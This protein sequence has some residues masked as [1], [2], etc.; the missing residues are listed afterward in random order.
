MENN[1]NVNRKHK[2][3]LFRM[4]FNDREALLSLYNAVNDSNYMDSEAI[5]IN[6]IEDVVYMGMKNDNS[7]LIANYLNL[8]EAQSTW[9]PNMPLR[10][11]FYF[12]SLFRGYIAQNKLDIYSE[13]LI[14]LPIPQYI[15]FYNGTRNIGERMELRLSDSFFY[16]EGEPADCKVDTGGTDI[17]DHDGESHIYHELN[18]HSAQPALECVVTY[19]N[20]NYGHNQEIVSKCR[21]LYEYSYLVEQ[22]RIEVRS[23]KPIEEAVD[24]AVR[25]CIDEGILADFLRRHRAEVMDMILTEYDEDLHIRSEKQISRKEGWED[26]RKK[27]WEDGRKKGWEDGQKKGHADGQKEEKERFVRT[28]LQ[29]GS[30]SDI[31][32]ADFAELPLERILEIKKDC[33]L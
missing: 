25:Q 9:N 8:Y 33:N 16:E 2:D 23:G 3:S 4:I 17:C 18:G 5:M 30:F 20:I 28:L 21:K 27:G 22:I 13:K 26:G 12:A 7:F 32:L 15:V 14:H 10:G 6:T 24:N 19:L 29:K 11:V 1:S 31:E